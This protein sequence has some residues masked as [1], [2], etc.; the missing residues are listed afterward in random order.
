MKT[1]MY[2]NGATGIAKLR[3]DGFVSMHGEGELLTRPLIFDHKKYMF[4]NFNG[5]LAAD[6]F[7]VE[8]NILQ[9]SDFIKGESTKTIVTWNGF[10]DISSLNGKPI[11]IRFKLKKG[12]LYSFWFSDSYEG[13]SLGYPAAGCK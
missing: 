6:I 7:D 13:T 12:D 2:S 10:P 9:S 4:I 8:N 1:G 11:K 5:E 3:R